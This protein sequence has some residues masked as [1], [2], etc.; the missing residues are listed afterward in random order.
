MDITYRATQSFVELK[1]DENETTIFKSDKK[2]IEGMIYGLLD[3]AAALAGMTGRSIVDYA[4]EFGL[5]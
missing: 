4:K 3:A 5:D 1:V 2:I